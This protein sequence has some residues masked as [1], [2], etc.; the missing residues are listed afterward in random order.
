MPLRADRDGEDDVQSLDHGH[1]IM[2]IVP[3]R[4]E[5]DADH[6]DQQTGSRHKLILAAVLGVGVLGGAGAVA[7]SMMGGSKHIDPVAQVPVIKADERPVKAR[8]A[9]PGGME[10]PNQD[11]LI[12]E[13][14]GSAAGNE[15]EVERLLPAPETPQAPPVQ[16]RP[17]GSAAPPPP[18]TTQE[19]FGESRTLTP[20]TPPSAIHPNAV[21]QQAV[22]PTAPAAPAAPAAGGAIP[23]APAVAA[24]PSAPV[25]AAT[26]VAPA[27]VAAVSPTPAPV[28]PAAPPRPLAAPA[29]AKAAPVAAATPAPAPAPLAAPTKLAAVT[30]ATPPAAT[31]RPVSGGTYLIQLG[32]LRSEADANKEWARQKKANADVLGSLSPDIVM[33]DLGAKGTFFRLRAG[34]LDEASAR[35]LCGDLTKRNTGCMVVRK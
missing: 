18:T 7:L 26:P 17:A 8:P 33:V 3:E 31:A 14:L 27:P 34:P 16:P 24:A 32:A 19:M 13:R 5:Y 1:D 9:D 35:S 30:P 10:V 22:H 28:A 15:P 4:F 23:S 21:Q 6:Q 25:A 11:K 2:D 20:V 12:Y 29:P